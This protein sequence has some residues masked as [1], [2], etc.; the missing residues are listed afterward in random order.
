MVQCFWYV[1][2]GDLW[3]VDY[4]RLE[5]QPDDAI[6]NTTPEVS[7]MDGMP[8]HKLHDILN[9]HCAF[10][11]FRVVCNHHAMSHSS[12][13]MKAQHIVPASTGKPGHTDGCLWYCAFVLMMKQRLW[14]QTSSSMCAGPDA[15]IG[16]HAQQQQ[17]PVS[18]QGLMNVDAQ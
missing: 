1:P 2:T 13:L 4:Q 9:L 8:S 15:D 18:P 3:R 6:S 12:C 11:A 14:H 16:T 10:V 7:A 17:Q 5:D